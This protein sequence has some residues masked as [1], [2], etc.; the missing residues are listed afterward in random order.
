M[1]TPSLSPKRQAE[2]MQRFHSAVRTIAFFKAKKAVQAQIRANGQR[3][4]DYSNKEI[5]LM[6]N[7][8]FAQHQEELINKAAAVVVTF[9]EFSPLVCAYVRTNAQSQATC[10]DN[11]ISVQILG[12]K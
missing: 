7:A 4:S 3:I 8:H 11:Q 9:S 10:S 1:A 6:A 2:R 5:S 12:S